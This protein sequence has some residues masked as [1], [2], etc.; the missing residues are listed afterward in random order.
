M[1]DRAAFERGAAARHLKSI[2]RKLH[3][4]SLGY[5]PADDP[6]GEFVLKSRQVTKA[7]IAQPNISNIPNDYLA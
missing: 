4:H 5:C 1:N 7:P 2:D 6:S 3:R